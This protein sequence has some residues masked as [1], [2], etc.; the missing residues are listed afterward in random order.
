MGTT[1][2]FS[3]LLNEFLPNELLSED[4]V[5]K[6]YLFQKMESDPTWLGGNL[7]VPFK[8]ANASSIS[9][10]ALTGSTDIAEDAYVRGGVASQVEV[11]GSMIFNWRDLQE[12]GKLSEQNFLK[13]LPDTIDD[14]LENMKNTVSINLLCG[15]AFGRLLANSAL[16]TEQQA[17]SATS[18]TSGGLAFV[19]RPDRFQIG[20][21]VI[22]KNDAGTTTTT[23]VSAANG[24]NINV[25]GVY[26]V[27]ARSG[28]TPTDLSGY[29]G[30]T[31]TRF[32]NDGAQTTAFASL[33]AALLPASVSGGS[34]T[35]YG[36]TKSLY[37]YL[38]SIAASGSDVTA[39]NIMEKI[40]DHLTKVSQL[41][42][43]KPDTILM[44]YKHL[45]SCIKVIE[46]SKGNYN[47]RAGETSAVQYGWDEIDVG[48]VV[49]RRCK[50][51]GT[52]E[53]DDDF[54]AFIDW[55]AIKFYSNQ[56]F[57]KMKTPDGL[58]YFTIRATTGYS[59]IVDIALAGEFVVN[60]PSYCGVLHSI[61]Y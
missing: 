57:R 14:F 56:M 43:G 19:D 22:V 28:V 45:G 32:Y 27:T 29:A 8:S 25:A 50:I 20:Q 9:Y 58:E 41:G 51:V 52:Q 42:K 16:T 48:S 15:A 37:P 3:A 30:D 55:R 59:L 35:L 13:I 24:I 61:S 4:F 2:S 18:A 1:R 49:G 31:S 54:I 46:A 38:Q 23:Y 11:F 5:K 60:R 39:T 44:S 34:T 10:S 6:N 12:H 36:Q 21:K 17:L 40:F 7:V 33:K 53:M 47:V 26:F